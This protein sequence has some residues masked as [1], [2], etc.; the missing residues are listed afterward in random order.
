MDRIIIILIP[1]LIVLLILSSVFSSCETAYSTLNPGKLETMIDRKEFGSKIIKKQYNFFNRMLALI[2]IWN[3]IA[4]IG[5]SSA[6]SYVMSKSLIGNAS[7]YSA[8]ISTAVL[9][10]IIVILGEIIPKLI[11]KSHP[12]KVAKIFCYPLQGLYYLFF[13]IIWLISK[14]SKDIYVTN[15][16]QDVKNLIDVAHTEGILEANES[17]MAQ[18]AL[19]LDTTKVRRHFVKLKDMSFVS[20]KA[21]ITEALNVFKETNY[22]R[23][24]IEKNGE[25]LGIVLLK[26]IFFLEKGKI[27]DYM[28]TIPT[29]SANSTLAIALETLRSQRAQMAF[30]TNNNSSRE[31]L[32]I[33][34]IEDILEEI[35]G[36]IYDEYD[37]EELKDFFE[38]SL[39]LFRVNG[40]VKMRE[41][42]SRMNLDFEIDDKLL[43]LNV[44]NFV[45]KNNNGK[46]TKSTKIE[47]QGVFF[48]VI[49]APNK[50]QKHYLFE[51]EIGT[52]A[53]VNVEATAEF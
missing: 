10:P 20:Y 24:P 51:V 13:P 9:T 48:K 44:Q 6:L 4:N 39:E 18:N 2:L 38:I 12:E 17:I 49:S 34:T 29:I 7:E 42:I 45:K 40:A 46:L 37:E 50:K 36:E 35:V 3:N 47:F 16:E 22:S 33:I 19:D 32:G 52:Q 26:D 31:V 27:I 5:L 25:F 23:L 30:V 28:K 41:L 11:A 21:N 1:V 53:P 43:N 15:T 14:I 8:L